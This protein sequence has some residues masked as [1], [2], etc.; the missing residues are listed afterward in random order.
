[1]VKKILS[2]RIVFS[3]EYPIKSSFENC[4]SICK[5]ITPKSLKEFIVGPE[6]VKYEFGKQ[7]S[8]RRY[9]VEYE[10]IYEH[11]DG[12]LEREVSVEIVDEIVKELV[13]S[14]SLTNYIELMKDFIYQDRHDGFL[15]FRRPANVEG[16]W[17]PDPL[18]PFLEHMYDRLLQKVA[19]GEM[20]DMYIDSGSI[21]RNVW[22]RSIEKHY[23]GW[24]LEN[25]SR[26]T[27]YLNHCLVNHSRLEWDVTIQQW[28]LEHASAPV[29]Y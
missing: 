16:N 19:R 23:Q 21:C 2:E 25:E 9:L 28:N 15:F 11:T 8:P 7:V 18:A 29:K 12:L 5:P 6:P 13:A 24:L 26:N 3:K 14:C 20:L 1:M 4:S 17:F 22:F 10:F 27:N